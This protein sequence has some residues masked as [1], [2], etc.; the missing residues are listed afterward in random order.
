MFPACTNTKCLNTKK[1]PV[2]KECVDTINERKLL[3]KRLSSLAPFLF[4]KGVD[5]NKESEAEQFFTETLKN[6]K[7]F[8]LYAALMLSHQHSQVSE[9]TKKQARGFLN[10]PA[11]KFKGSLIEKILKT[12]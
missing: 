5:K 3:K 2:S 12:P 10:D 9:T 11:N 4:K 1:I 8:G 6:G 7:V